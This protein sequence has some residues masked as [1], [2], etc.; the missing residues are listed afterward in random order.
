MAEGNLNA[1]R[2]YIEEINDLSLL[3]QLDA[4]IIERRKVLVDG[5]K[6]TD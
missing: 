4:L 3:D 5:Q 1:I 2:T 6:N